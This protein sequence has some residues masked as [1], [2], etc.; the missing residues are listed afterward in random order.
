MDDGKVVEMFVNKGDKRAED[1]LKDINDLG[2]KDFI[3][4]GVKDKIVDGESREVIYL[5]TSIGVSN[6]DCL[7]IL[8][9]ASKEILNGH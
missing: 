3:V 6:K 8:E 4:I 7:W 2:Y 5:N 1:I 9:T